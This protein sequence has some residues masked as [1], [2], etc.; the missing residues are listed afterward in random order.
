[1]ESTERQTAEAEVAFGGSQRAA[2]AY[3]EALLN[4][5]EGRGVRD[6]VAEELR[7]LVE[8][9]FR[10]NPQFE[11]LITGPIMTRSKKRQLLR[12]TFRGN[13][14]DTLAD[15]LGVLCENDRLGLLRA[16]RAEYR[17]LA[18]KRAGRVR[19]KVR[20]ARE[21]T[22]EQRE[23]LAEALRGS[24]NREPV[25]ETIVRP[26]LIGGVQVQVGDTVIDGSVSRR[27][28]TIRN[29]LLKSSSH[30][31]QSQRDRVDPD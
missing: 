4:V 17:R 19:V 8:E 9:V 28:E 30:V 14:S 7:S 24:L 3:A 23:E 11:R 2:Q 13:A 5:A 10:E 1:M 27:I 22:D 25:I 6:E 26:E 16:I 20:A 29:Q 31:I 15:F 18:E 21:L 12:E